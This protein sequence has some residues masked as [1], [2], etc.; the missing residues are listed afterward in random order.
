METKFN[1]QICTSKAQSEA[2]LKL[3]LKKETADC[4]WVHQINF[5]DELVW[6]AKMGTYTQQDAEI[7]FFDYIPAWSLHRMLRMLPKYVQIETYECGRK[8][9]AALDLELDAYLNVIYKEGVEEPC[10]DQYFYTNDA[11]ESVCRAFEWL[12]KEGYFNKE[13]LV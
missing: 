5:E 8:Y 3:G 11:Y 1:L 7:A 4:C 10:H 2:L 13:Y 6:S 9:I 12:I